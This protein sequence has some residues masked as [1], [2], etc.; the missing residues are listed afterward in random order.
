MSRSYKPYPK[1]K[2]SGIEWLGDVP[3]HWEVRRLK[4]LCSMKSGEGITN[5]S[6]DHVGKYP[7]YG[8]NG[9]RG[10]TNRYTHDGE[11]VLIGRQGALCGNVYIARGRFWASEHAVVVSMQNNHSIRWLNF[12]LFA[13]NL[14]KYSTASA[15][16]GLAVERISNISVPVPQ[17]SEQSTIATYLDHQT[18]RIDQL[19][20][21]KEQFIKLLQEKRTALITAAVTGR[22]DVR[23]G[24]PY[25]KYKPSGIEWLGDV[26]EHWEVKAIK[27]SFQV[28]GGSTPKSGD[29]SFWDGDIVWVTPADLSRLESKW[30]GDSGRKITLKG[31]ASCGSNLIPAGTIILSTRAPIGSMAIASKPLCTNQGCKSLVPNR[32]TNT[33]FFSYYLSICVEQLNVRGKGTTFLELSEDELGAFESISPPLPEQSAIATYLDHQTFRIDQLIEKTRQSIELLKEKRT[34][35]ITA[36]VTGKIDVRDWTPEAA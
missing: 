27:R 35:L 17:F 12:L 33:D 32:N 13:M 8:G 29:P 7:V 10:Y 11:F 25:P 34:A 26:P 15:Q 18:A 28:V 4:T 36:A 21:K 9:I 6:I 3:E 14:N 2:P 31:L 5:D 20:D 1:Y 23:T 24:K 16:P 22:F 30:I 19:I